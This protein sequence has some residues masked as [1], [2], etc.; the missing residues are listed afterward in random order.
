MTEKQEIYR[1][2]ICGNIV[3]ILHNSNGILECC[4]NPMELLKEK[5]EGVGTEK[6]LPVMEE[7][8][9]C[10]KVKI[11]SIPHPMEENHCIEMVEILADGKIY[12]KLLKPGDKPEAE[13]KLNKKDINQIQ[14]REY[15]S[16]HGL[17][18]S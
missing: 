16:I 17:W 13:F 18:R 7:T 15:C 6:H 8:N 12:R 4:K 1:C 3:E 5:E 2:N 9:E 11:G 10:V 14:I